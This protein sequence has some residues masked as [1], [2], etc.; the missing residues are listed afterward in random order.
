MLTFSLPRSESGAAAVKDK[1]AFVSATHNNGAALFA[2]GAVAAA[3]HVRRLGG[4][5]GVSL[6]LAGRRRRYISPI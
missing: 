5:C 4:G 1:V 2:M 3:D 6:L